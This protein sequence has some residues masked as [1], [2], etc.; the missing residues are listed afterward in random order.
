MYFVFNLNLKFKFK[1]R[2]L[3]I[4]DSTIS[5]LRAGILYYFSSTANPILYNLMSRKFRAAFRHT[6]CCWFRCGSCWRR[7]RATSQAAP[8]PVAFDNAGEPRVPPHRPGFAVTPAD[9]ER[10]ANDGLSPQTQVLLLYHMP[11]FGVSFLVQFCCYY[12]FHAEAAHKKHKRTQHRKETVQIKT[13]VLCIIGVDL[14]GIL[15]EADA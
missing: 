15:G 6:V 2:A 12:R 11:S 4:C 7:A 10:S 5:C 8:A 9:D 13:L 3:S 14:T 1:E